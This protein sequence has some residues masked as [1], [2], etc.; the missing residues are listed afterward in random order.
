MAS[1]ISQLYHA[2]EITGLKSEYADLGP[3]VNGLGAGVLPFELEAPDNPALNSVRHYAGIIVIIVYYPGALFG[4]RFDKPD[5]L[6]H[7][8][9]VVKP[10]QCYDN[11]PLLKI[12]FIRRID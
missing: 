7:D 8:R 6:G 1:R 12:C 11:F 5:A 2:D 9:V 3:E 4:S 10:L